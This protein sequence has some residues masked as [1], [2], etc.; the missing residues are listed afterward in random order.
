LVVIAIIG[1]LATLSVLSL[2]NAR[3]KARDAK[4]VADVKQ[5]MT[6]LELYFNDNQQYTSSLAPG[7]QIASGTTVYM[8]VVPTPPT[9]PVAIQAYTYTATNSNASYTLEY[10]LEG[11]VGSIPAGLHTANPSALY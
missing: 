2:N 7:E 4:R 3:A 5:M 8:N 1:L 9:P 10:Y 11:Q 6:A